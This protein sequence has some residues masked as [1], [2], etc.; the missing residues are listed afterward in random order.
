MAASDPSRQASEVYESRLA[1]DEE[2]AF[3]AA[4]LA[5]DPAAAPAP[6]ETSLAG[7]SDDDDLVELSLPFDRVYQVG[8]ED[9][10][11]EEFFQKHYYGTPPVD[12]AS[13]AAGSGGAV[14]TEGSLP[15]PAPAERC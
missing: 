10:R 2:T 11:Q 9:A 13:T 14:A 4:A 7:D 12:A 6:A 3:Y 15:P 5:G 1:L 8:A